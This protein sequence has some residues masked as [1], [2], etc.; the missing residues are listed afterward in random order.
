[1]KRIVIALA[2]MLLAA[3][4]FAVPAQA[5]PSVSLLNAHRLPAPAGAK[6]ALLSCT[7]TCFHYAGYQQ[8]APPTGLT[9][10]YDGKDI[11]KP[12]L[13]ATDGHT[14]EETAALS[15]TTV[16]TANVVEVGWNVDHSVNGDYDPH[17]FVGHWINGAFQGY[18][19][20]SF[21]K[22]TKVAPFNCGTAAIAWPG[23]DLNG[24]VGS[25]LR[26]GIEHTGSGSTGAWFITYGTAFVGYFPDSI[27][28]TGVFTSMGF[29]ENFGEVV[30][31]GPTPCSQMGTGVYATAS[32]GPRDAT[33]TY[34]VGTPA[35][36]YNNMINTDPAYY[37]AIYSTGSTRTFRYGGDNTAC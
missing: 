4:S 33:L 23:D 17:L 28:G 18:N 29:F 32:T 9:G 37:N 26:F 16:S 27:W 30:S 21:V 3:L 2:G 20:S 8:T 10:I 12:V 35:P 11:A 1:M 34:N 6:R 36:T 19:S 25:L 31:S 14:L 5:A 22:C 7:S 15:S 24:S 13:A